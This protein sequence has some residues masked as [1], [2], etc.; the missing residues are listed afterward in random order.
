LLGGIVKVTPSSKVVG[1]MAMFMTTNDLTVDDLLK[2][3]DTLSFPESVKSLMRGDLGQWKFGWPADLQKVILKDE[4]PY[5]N[6]P[7]AHLEPID[8]EKEKQQFDLEF[9]EA[10]GYASLLSYLLYP[11]VYRQYYEHHSK[12]GDISKLP[13]IPFFFGLKPNEEIT[14]EI[15]KGKTILIEYLNANQ[16]DEYGNR[17]VIFRLNG[18]IRTVIVKDLSIQAKSI[19]NLKVTRDDQVGTPLQG[20][21]SKIL[22]SSGDEVIKN[23]P[24][25]IIEAMKME[26]TVTA[27]YD[28]KISELYLSE[29]SL[30]EQDDAVLSIAK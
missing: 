10:D 4:Q 16:A 24:L 25:F 29:K 12:Y 30:V 8:W 18:A 13:T 7:N 14:V 3:G 6:K 26:T 23:Q 21:L 11:K 1:D 15:S 5:T 9:P 17:L 27:P 20:S 22:V 28:G 2:K 19:T